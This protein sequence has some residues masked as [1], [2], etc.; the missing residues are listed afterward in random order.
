[1]LTCC[2]P[3]DNA[4]LARDVHYATS[5]AGPTIVSRKRILREHLL[6]GR[7]GRKPAATVVDAVDEVKLLESRVV[8][9]L[10]IAEHAC[11]SKTWLDS[12][13][14]CQLS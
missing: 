6:D 9:S 14:V 3:A 12:G 13:Q 1:M 2:W 7:A 8:G 4:Q 5:A 10:V 11:S